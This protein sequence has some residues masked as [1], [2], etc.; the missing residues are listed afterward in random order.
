MAQKTQAW[1][2][3]G[4]TS[5]LTLGCF[6]VMSL[7]GLMLY[8]VPQGRIAY[9]I[10][11]QML[12]LTKEQWGNIHILSSLIFIIAGAVHTYFNWRSLWNYLYDRAKRGIKL[13]RELTSS[14]L[15]VSLLVIG[16]IVEVPPLNYLLKLNSLIKEAWIGS[17]DDEPPFGHA[18]IL[19][20]KIF[21]KKTN[22]PL[23]AALAK[24]K[25]NGIVGVS[26]KKRL[27][28]IARQ[29]DLSSRDIYRLIK[30]LEQK[31]QF[32]T[33][34]V[35]SPELVEEKFSGTGVGAKRLGELIRTTGVSLEEV[36][37]RF[38]ANG[39]SLDIDM[40]L[41]KIAK[42]GDTTPL[43]VLKA[44]LVEGYRIPK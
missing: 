24:L 37:Q 41:K 29:N 23:T 34:I 28:D 19:T 26:P 15:I 22:I 40:N 6:V 4:F 9:W 31:E 7:T 33:S 10:E 17:P 13:K 44:M 35:W 5:L 8:I 12:G 2:W 27:V 16:G 39:I 20:F 21:C 18:E 11:W 25:A 30:E 32:R 42:E 14:S 3:R 36:K 38:S 1:H 43:E